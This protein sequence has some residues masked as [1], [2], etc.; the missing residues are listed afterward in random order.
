MPTT[1]L[2]PRGPDP[3]VPWKLTVLDKK[4]LRTNRILATTDDDATADSQQKGQT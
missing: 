1:P 4:F 2:P 3:V